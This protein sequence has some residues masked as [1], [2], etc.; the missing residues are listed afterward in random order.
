V[1]ITGRH[2]MHRL[3][4]AFELAARPDAAGKEAQVVHVA[5]G[6]VLAETRLSLASRPWAAR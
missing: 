2:D 6:D 3:K 4:T 1:R 5:T